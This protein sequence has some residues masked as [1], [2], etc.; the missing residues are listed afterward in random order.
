MSGYTDDVIADHG[1]S[2]VGVSFLQ[3]PFRL[4]HLAAQLCK[5][6]DTRATE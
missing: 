5:A 3:K 2:E 6:L 1:V 4:G